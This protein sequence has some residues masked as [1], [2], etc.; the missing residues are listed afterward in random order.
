MFNLGFSEL[1][2]LGIIALI[3]IGPKQLPEIARV[4]ARMINEFKRATGDITSTIAN[5]KNQA[6]DAVRL[7]EEQIREQLKI[8]IEEASVSA[9]ENHEKPFVPT[10]I[11][12]SNPEQS[13]ETPEKSLDSKVVKH[14]E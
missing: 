13:Q 9:E 7:T 8:K 2:V 4:I 12:D 5:V 6:N 14:D 3:F 11:A 1:I 10:P